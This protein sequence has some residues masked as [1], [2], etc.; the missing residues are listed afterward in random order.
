MSDPT[1]LVTNDDGIDAHG[2]R[3]LAT[4]LE[5]VGDVTVVAPAD[6]QSWA[7]RDMTWHAGPTGIEETSFG[8]AVDGTPS[9]AVAVALS[10]LDIDPDIVVSGVNDG[11]NLAAHII[12]RSGTVGA[13]MEA[14]HLG[15]PAVAVS[16]A[17]HTDPEPPHPDPAA[18]EMPAEAAAFVTERALSADVFDV[19]EFLNV[20]VPAYAEQP[21]VTLTRPVREYD[22][23]PQRVDADAVE[24]RD[25]GWQ[26]FLAGEPPADPETDRH[27]VLHGDVSVTPM[28]LPRA[29]EPDVTFD[30]FDPD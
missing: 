19:A 27:A 4:A 1:V 25:G 15:V 2:I 14:A 21:Q 22:L 23:E 12:E 9:D 16:T 30:G 28:R 26:R 18:F 17:D 11:M 6:N 29:V 24:L 3:A 7:G 5:T 8:Y 10:V 20:N 13:A